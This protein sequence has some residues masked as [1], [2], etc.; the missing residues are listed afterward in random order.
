MH[1]RPGGLDAAAP[2]LSDSQGVQ[3]RSCTTMPSAPVQSLHNEAGLKAAVMQRVSAKLS[4]LQPVESLLQL[5]LHL[6][7]PSARDTGQRLRATAWNAS[8]NKP[9]ERLC[10]AKLAFLFTCSALLS[11]ARRAPSNRNL[12]VHNRHIPYHLRAHAPRTC[13]GAGGANA[14]D[15]ADLDAL[16]LAVGVEDLRF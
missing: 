6:P 10:S 4:S 13:A 2:F 16:L 12:R 15:I 9:S 1:R 5:Y 14:L 11:V 7:C 8:S 3:S